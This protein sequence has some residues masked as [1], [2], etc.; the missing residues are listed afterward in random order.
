[1]QRKAEKEVSYRGIL[2]VD[3]VAGEDGEDPETLSGGV[4]VALDVQDA[5]LL[6]VVDVPTLNLQGTLFTAVFF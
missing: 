1:M 4:G 3:A 5:A 2:G 6:Q